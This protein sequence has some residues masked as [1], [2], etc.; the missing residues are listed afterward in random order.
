[1]AL[2]Q[3]RKPSDDLLLEINL[4]KNKLKIS[5]YAQR[6]FFF[7]LAFQKKKKKKRVPRIM[8]CGYRINFC[9]AKSIV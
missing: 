5:V 8:T 3:Q 9:Y 2:S 7:V 4:Y 1:M 6:S